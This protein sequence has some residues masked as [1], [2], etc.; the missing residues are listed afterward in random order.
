METNIG[1]FV[2]GKT[3][4][5]IVSRLNQETVR[6]LNRPDVKERLLNSGLEVIASSPEQLAAAVKSSVGTF[7]KLIK[8]LG[9]RSN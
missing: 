5:T 7:G 3:P 8:D 4:V 1:L 2:Q 6:V 9:I